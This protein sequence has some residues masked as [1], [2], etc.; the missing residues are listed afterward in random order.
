MDTVC[1]AFLGPLFL[2]PRRHILRKPKAH[3]EASCRFSEQQP[4]KDISL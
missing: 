3:E 2:D 4:S 1:L